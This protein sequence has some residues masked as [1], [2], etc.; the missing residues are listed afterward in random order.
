[1]PDLVERL[2]EPL[3][4]VRKFLDE[5]YLIGSRRT[6]TFAV[7]EVFIIDDRPVP[8]LRG[9]VIVLQDGGFSDDEVID[10]LLGHD[11]AIGRAPIASL[12]EGRKAEVR[13]IAQALA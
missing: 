4:R 10:W 2:D 6:G 13:R 8:S 7:P 9:T 3:A 11:E 1:M 12:R 5:K